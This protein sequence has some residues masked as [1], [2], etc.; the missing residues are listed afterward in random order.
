[1]MPP[2]AAVACV[3]AA[4]NGGER[5]GQTANS[6]G[7]KCSVPFKLPI[8]WRYADFW[9][10]LEENDLRLVREA[11]DGGNG[12]ILKVEA[13]WFR[14]LYEAI[15]L[16]PRSNF[17]E[18]DP[19]CTEADFVQKYEAIL[20]LPESP[21]LCLASGIFQDDDNYYINME[22]VRGTD[23][24]CGRLGEREAK[25][26]AMGALSGLKV[27]HDHG[28]TH[29]DVSLRN[30]MTSGDRVM[31]VDFD[32]VLTPQSSRPTRI[33]G[34]AKYLAPECYEC[35]DYSEASDIWAMGV[36][37]YRMLTGRYPFDLR[38]DGIMTEGKWKA[39]TR[40][41][42][43]RRTD[44]VSDA[45][46]DLIRSLLA[47]NKHDRIAS[48]EAA[49]DHPWFTS[50]DSPPPHAPPSPAA[51][52]HRPPSPTASDSSS[53]SSSGSSSSSDSHTSSSHT[54]IPAAAAAAANHTALRT[55]G[56]M[57]AALGHRGGWCEETDR[58]HPDRD[59]GPDR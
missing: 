30:I 45:A 24:D 7:Q 47:F 23:A 42:R 22:W 28:M 49:L 53:D 3:A 9:S 51:V 33:I 40:G 59:R 6:E 41:V 54:D 31:L 56:T 25:R 34:T 27:L 14:G 21:H 52:S 36:C 12:L 46:K 39:L 13:T 20:D 5:G 57:G 18:D 48:V 43:F 55:I 16:V 10:M 15:K 19:Q 44:G 17:M 2:E 11:D 32:T 35:L 29:A 50:P 38:D 1:M 37:I 58:G 4:D 8:V 26:I